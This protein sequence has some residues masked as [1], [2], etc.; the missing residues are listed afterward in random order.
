VTYNEL[1]Q[2]DLPGLHSQETLQRAGILAPEQEQSAAQTV[3]QEQ[4]PGDLLKQIDLVDLSEARTKYVKAKRALDEFS[5]LSHL[6][7][8]MKLGGESKVRVTEALEQ[9]RQEYESARLEYI[10]AN[11]ELHLQEQTEMRKARFEEYVTMNAGAMD[12]ARGLWNKLGNVNYFEYRKNQGKEIQ[13]RVGATLAKAANIRTA[14]SLG[15]LGTGLYA[16]ATAAGAGI[17]LA[18]RSYGGFGSAMGSKSLFEQIRMAKNN[19]P[20]SA[21]QFSNL[22]T[23]EEVQNQMAA[24]EARAML[25]GQNEEKL[26]ENSDYQA[27]LR[28]QDYLLTERVQYDASKASESLQ[29]SFKSSEEAITQAQKAEKRGRA[30]TTAAALAAGVVGA[31]GVAKA[32]EYW[33][34]EQPE[35][36]VKTGS[37]DRHLSPEKSADLGKPEGIELTHYGKGTGATIE[38]EGNNTFVTAGNRGIEGALQDLKR[39]DPEKYK[40]MI[41][42]IKEQYPGTQAKDSTLIHRAVKKLAEQNNFTVDGGG[43]DLSRVDF[44]KVVLKPTADG[45]FELQLDKP[46]LNFMD[47]NGN[48]A[49][50]SEPDQVVIESQPD[51]LPIDTLRAVPDDAPI[52]TLRRVGE[53]A[54]ENKIGPEEV[55]VEKLD[56]K[57]LIPESENS[58]SIYNIAGE[59]A[60][61]RTNNT[62]ELALSQV[63]QYPKTSDALKH[64]LKDDYTAFMKE[65]IQLDARVINRLQKFP[66]SQ[67]MQEYAHSKEIPPKQ[68]MELRGLADSIN[69]LLVRS[70]DSERTAIRSGTI[71]QLLIR[72]ASERLN[73]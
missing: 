56:F 43:K 35:V 33:N 11:L 44:A 30:K 20:I 25:S 47:D 49:G 65:K 45:Q 50:V 6:R 8:K 53:T 28:V 64:L 57:N 59:A 51:K 15:L 63:D 71:R 17:L 14:I 54:A 42:W 66:V 55:E 34:G 19:R 48:N 27:L 22:H 21:D 23:V 13:N 62:Y 61:S 26:L 2:A 69:D 4:E 9:A 36:S 60:E 73:K 3:E 38:V 10:G 37:G 1:G 40:G 68:L 24:L 12:K 16:G 72:L 32:V 58:N 67:F 7:N 18:R 70:S 31:G 29:G 52:D 39:Q 41:N 5:A 46:S